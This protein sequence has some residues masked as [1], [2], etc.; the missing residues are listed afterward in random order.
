MVKFKDAFGIIICNFLQDSLL[1]ELSMLMF[2][3]AQFE[4]KTDQQNTI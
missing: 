3:R 4:N 2:H 1:L